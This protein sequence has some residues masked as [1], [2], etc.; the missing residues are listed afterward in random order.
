MEK[1]LKVH[2]VHF[3]SSPGGIELLLS[4]VVSS[5]SDVDFSVFTIRPPLAGS[6]DVYKESTL[7]RNHGSVNNI[8]AFIR[9][10]KYA[11][12]HRDEVFYLLNAG[13][14]FL[15]AVRAAGAGRIIYNIRGTKYWS[16]ALQGIVR[17]T[18]WRMALNSRVRLIANSE[19]SRQ[20]FNEKIR[21]GRD[22]E[23]I[24]N[25]VNSDNLIFK[26]GTG[27]ERPLKIIYAGRLT[28]GKNL[29]RW[30]ETAG[31]IHDQMPDT[32][33]EIYGSGPMEECLRQKIGRLDAGD[34]ITLKGFR[35]DIEAVFHDAGA[36]L[37]L[38]EYESFGNVVV[39]SILCGTPV[40]ASAIPSIREI[41]ANHPVYLVE[42]GSGIEER[43]LDKL[44][45][46]EL[47]RA[48]LPE[49][50]A[51]FRKRFSMQGHLEKLMSLFSSFN[52][53]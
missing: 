48:E 16:G 25:P 20:V 9:L 15:L 35:P 1:L 22:I 46:L 51:E 29:L 3:Y 52:S 23:V 8:E 2:L 53:R 13:P 40:I 34:Y 45:N 33:F 5:C 31:L 26:A 21:P 39:E 18:L 12:R 32:L 36:L 28:K 4:K 47:L 49:T 7:T 42:P 24:Y 38:S 10:W 43:I 11:R 50:A 17:K 44:N 30:I 6:Y 14:Y 27:N 37:F 41:F 19:Y